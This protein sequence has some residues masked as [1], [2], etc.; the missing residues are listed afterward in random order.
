MP[1]NSEDER[2]LHRPAC[3]W[4]QDG[5]AS[6]LETSSAS[7]HP[8]EADLRLSVAGGEVG[9]GLRGGAHGSDSV[10]HSLVRTLRLVPALL[11]AALVGAFGGAAGALAGAGGGQ[12]GSR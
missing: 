8:V 11:V 3:L 12:E 10:A 4:S 7:T 2:P 5:G 9:L 6:R 1:H